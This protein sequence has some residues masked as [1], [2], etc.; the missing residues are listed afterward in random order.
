MLVSRY[1]R[2]AATPED[3]ALRDAAVSVIGNPWL[4]K[5]NWDAYV[6]LENGE[7]DIQAREMVFSWL[8]G[9]LIQDFFELL[10]DG[11]TGDVRRLIYWLRFAP[12][13]DDMWFALGSAAQARHDND[14]KEFKSRATGRL[15]DLEGTTSDNNAFV[16]RIGEF[17]AVEFGVTGNAFYLLRWEDLPRE[18]IKVLTSGRIREF[19]HIK[20]LKPK[21]RDELKE[22][23]KSHTDAPTTLKSWEQ[24][25]DDKLLPVL[26]VNPK[27]RPA[28]VPELEEL[29]R[30]RDVVVTDARAKGGTLRIKPEEQL[31]AVARRLSALG[32]VLRSGRGWSRE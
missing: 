21:P 11:G 18:L 28:C 7:P 5:S 2:S 29:L 16:M 20:S 31:V 24:I 30:G 8:K 12:Y 23:K 10:S 15:L 26:R 3:S 17:L 6:V 13:I 1:S 19:V 32:L 25:F 4:R 27:D 14:F 22:F 9:R